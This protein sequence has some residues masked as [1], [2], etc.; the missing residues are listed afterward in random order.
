MGIDP[1]PPG[2]RACLEDIQNKGATP[3][4]VY[5]DKSPIGVIG[6]SDTVR[7][8]AAR[9]MTRLRE[10]GVSRLG[11]LSGDHA[12]AVERVAQNLGITW[13]RAGLKPDQKLEELQKLQ[14]AGHRVMVVGD[15]INDAPALARANVGVAMGAGGTEVA[16]ETAN[17]VLTRDDISRLPLLIRLSRRMLAVIKINVALGLGFNVLAVWGG[18]AGIL[19]PIQAAVMHSA[20]VV[21]VVFSSA[22]LA[23]AKDRDA[24]EGL[25]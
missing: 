9:T 25:S 11:I 20:G 17:I 24:E 7:P 15:G 14:Q 19:G 3:L 21:I 10:L 4:L 16:L 13:I 8:E 5:R 2:L 22:A 1:L 23:V 18:A 6:V 12:Q